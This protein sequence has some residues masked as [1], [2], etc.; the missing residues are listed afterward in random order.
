MTT[1][2]LAAAFLASAL[3]GA[4]P[5]RAAFQQ[6]ILSPE[7]AALGG[8]S[9]AS[10]HD[11]PSLFSNPAQLADMKQADFYFVYDQLYAGM[12]GV[13]PIAQGLI[14]A[15]TPSR[16]GAFGLGFGVFRAAGLMEE[17]T[18]ALTYARALS[19]RISA[20]VTGK[21]LYH[22]FMVGS[23]ALA[24]GDPVFQNGR[25]A[26]ALSFDLGLVAKAAEPLRL[27]FTLRNV[28]A[29]D[30]GLATPD[31]VPREAQAGA[32][33]DFGPRRQLFLTADVTYRQDSS[34]SSSDRLVPA[35]GL[36][37]RFEDGRFAF[38]LG[39]TSLAFSAGF[40]LHLGSIGLDYAFVLNRNLINGSIGAHQLGVSWRFGTRSQEGL[41]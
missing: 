13:G 35:V 37:K 34:L 29:P 25:S 28:N 33:Y 30:V 38:R 1:M 21:Q 3:A 11:S 12:P 36:Q 22:G 23:D 4:A 40:G 18:L 2:R 16:L 7:S 32:S 6:P 8:A 41:R 20:G 10:S 27:G 14:S 5:A 19:E 31:R 39:L 24:A 26:S 9:L 17:R 15:G